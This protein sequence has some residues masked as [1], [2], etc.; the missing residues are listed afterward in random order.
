MLNTLTGIG[1]PET[2][3]APHATVKLSVLGQGGVPRPTESAVSAVI[4]NVI[5]T[6]PKAAGTLT[7]SPDKATAPGA[8][9]LFFTPGQTIANLVVVPVGADGKIDFTNTS[10]GTIQIIATAAGW[11]RA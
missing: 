8:A 9:N 1:A 2:A 4:L 5:A 7:V 6:Q 3:V 10:N 11:V